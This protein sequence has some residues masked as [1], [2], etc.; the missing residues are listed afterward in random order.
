MCILQQ[1]SMLDS[2]GSHEDKQERN[3]MP[4]DNED[5]SSNSEQNNGSI[6]NNRTGRKKVA[7][8]IHA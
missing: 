5:E 8:F 2:I 6:G 7:D 1:E 3:D 4:F